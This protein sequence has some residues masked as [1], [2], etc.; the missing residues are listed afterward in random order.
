MDEL[1]LRL[2]PFLKS[3]GFQMQARTCNRISSDGLTHV[4]NFQMGRF[5][6]PGANYIPWFRSKLHGKFTVNIGIYVPEVYAEF[7]QWSKKGPPSLV[8]EADCCINKRLGILG[9]KRQ[10]IWWEL[11]DLED[12]TDE[13]RQRIERD[14]LPFL[15]RFETRDRVLAVLAD[16][17]NKFV[18]EGMRCEI[19]AIILAARG[20]VADATQILATYFQQTMEVEKKKHIQD[21]ALRLGLGKFDI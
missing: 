14:A 19:R 17:E 12:I 18:L 9:H 11:K 2:R 21:L 5:D 8:R 13:I 1:Q 10:D 3:H 6:P 7:F 15:E 4:I 20:Q 16:A